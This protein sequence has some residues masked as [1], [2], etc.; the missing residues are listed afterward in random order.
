[1]HKEATIIDKEA[2]NSKC[3]F[4]MSSVVS[5]RRSVVPDSWHHITSTR[6]TPDCARA[7]APSPSEYVCLLATL[8]REALGEL[9]YDVSLLLYLPMQWAEE[10]LIRQELSG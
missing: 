6:F 4:C 10:A 5:S 3:G 9:L 1:M 8:D 2:T 7:S